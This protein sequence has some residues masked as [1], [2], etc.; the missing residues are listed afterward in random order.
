MTV[1]HKAM[2]ITNEEFDAMVGNIKTSM[3]KLE[4]PRREMREF[5]AI[6]E[7]TRKQI[8]EKR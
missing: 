6:V 8:V 4:V 1:A 3:E 2:R 5:L 7:T